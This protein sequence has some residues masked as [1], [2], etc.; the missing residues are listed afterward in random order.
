LC[1]QEMDKGMEENIKI[2][3]MDLGESKGSLKS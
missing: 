1:I 2:V 3:E